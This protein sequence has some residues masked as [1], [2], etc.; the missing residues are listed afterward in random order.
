MSNEAN[1]KSITPS[2]LLV[3]KTTKIRINLIWSGSEIL[4]VQSK[5]CTF[6]HYLSSTFKIKHNAVEKGMLLVP[7]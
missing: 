5:G 1:A 3:F 2:K 7:K 6:S 4:I